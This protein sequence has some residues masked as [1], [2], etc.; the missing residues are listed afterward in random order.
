VG[1]D[2]RHADLR[3]AILSDTNLSG[4]L[5]EETELEGADLTTARNKPDSFPP[6]AQVPL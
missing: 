3:G 1:V 5:F 4:A 2:F 6:L